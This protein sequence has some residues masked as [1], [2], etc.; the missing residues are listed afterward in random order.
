MAPF[1]IQIWATAAVAAAL[2]LWLALDGGGYDLVVRQ[3]VGLGVWWLLAL[4]VAFGLLPRARPP[5]EA[6]L[7]AAGL[8]ALIAVTALGLLDTESVGRT[9]TEL[10][11]VLTYGGLIVFA[12][13]VLR[14]DLWRPAAIGL[15]AAALAVPVIAVASRVVPDAFDAVVAEEL[16]GSRL[17]YPLGY[18]NAVAAWC[19]MAF[20]IG[21]S[22]SAHARSPAVRRLAAA[23]LPIAAVGLYLTYSRAG[24]AALAVAVAL[25]ALAG[26]NRG[27]I[28]AHA[29]A[30]VTTAALVALVVRSQPEIA[31]GTGADGGG[32]VALA[33]GAACATTAAVAWASTRARLD[34]L[35][36]RVTPGI[37]ALGA[38][39]VIICVGL[40]LALGPRLAGPA[41]GEVGGGLPRGPGDPAG[42]LVEL[43][44]SRPELWGSAVDAF[45]SSPLIGIGG[46]S[47][48]FWYERDVPDGKV[49]RDA[50][51]LYLE[52]LAETGVLGLAALLAL[53]GG[54][55]MLVI[56][57]RRD[58]R[59]TGEVGASAGL[60][61][62]YAAFLVHAG[63]DWIWDFT[64]LAVLGLGAALIAG[65]ARSRPVRT[66]R[67]LSLRRAGIV[68]A[69]ALAGAIQVPGLVSENR[70]RA[71]EGALVSGAPER[72]LELAGEAIDA[73]PWRADAY[74]LRG[75]L[76]LSAGD[77]EEAR[78]DALEAIE[79]EQTNWRHRLLLARIEIRSDD[80][81]G[82]EAALDA[83][84]ELRPQAS[85]PAKRLRS[86]LE[87]GS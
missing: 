21:L 35:R 25:V 69:A 43:G 30:G 42:R 71:A 17:A 70:S 54:L 27:M 5:R 10:A 24:W 76:R 6:R 41:P 65:S 82:A 50:H 59:S 45:A 48:Q 32:L 44:G 13:F 85:G 68:A 75:Y 1:P 87:Q 81:T 46:G 51:S 37:A 26:R 16:V 47:F 67:R 80:P 2:P 36:G 57:A 38:S 28:A 39:V 34:R 22:L 3:E 18:W 14:P 77:L 31:N 33:L 73:A 74:A 4:T 83:L 8:L 84:V 7:A 15:G 49:V 55:L 19:A 62:A 64:A 53:L 86:R 60:L 56:R 72:A 23:A 20:G 11:R 66:T 12:W 58:A 9:V 78:A 79:R 40:A 29:A 61:G 63:V 52:T